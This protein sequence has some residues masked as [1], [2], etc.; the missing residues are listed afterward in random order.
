MNKSVIEL[1]KA[2]QKLHKDDSGKEASLRKLSSIYNVSHQNLSN[3]NKGLDKQAHIFDFIEKAR[4][5]LGWSETTAYRK[6][7]KGSL[8]HKKEVLED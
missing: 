8:A 6:A 4:K 2:L 1:I 3:W 7:I 5:S